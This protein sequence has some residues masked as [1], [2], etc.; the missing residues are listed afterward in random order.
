MTGLLEIRRRFAGS[1]SVSRAL[2]IVILGMALSGLAAA[3]CATTAPAESAA[4]PKT[5]VAI[6]DFI[7][8]PTNLEIP[9][10]T[11]VTW[12]NQDTAQHTSTHA[13]TGSIQFRADGSFDLT[14]SVFNVIENEK[15]G[16][17]SYTFTKPGTY[18]YFCLW[19]NAMRGTVIVK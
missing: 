17:G 4:R 3:A 7:Y 14:D 13:A 11:T 15:G 12:T 19:H 16:S 8:L 10:G 5:T 18:E 2:R 6:Q 9:V 1:V